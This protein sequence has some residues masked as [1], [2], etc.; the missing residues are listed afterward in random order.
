M[1][2]DVCDKHITRMEKKVEKT[3][4]WLDDTSPEEMEEDVSDQKNDKSEK[5]DKIKEA[6]CLDENSLDEMEKEVSDINDK[7]NEK[8]TKKKRLNAQMTLSLMI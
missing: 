6:A 1:E 5:N 2:D 4:E 3:I 8:Y 7:K